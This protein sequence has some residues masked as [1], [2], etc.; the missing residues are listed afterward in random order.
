MSYA[1]D[2]VA[3]LALRTAA[4]DSARC[5]DVCDAPIEDEAEASRGLYV[6]ARGGEVHYEEPHLCE[7][8]ATA[9]GVTA[10]AAW[11]V[12]EEEG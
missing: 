9:I 7:S 5:C 10:L 11:S 6:W 1:V 2:A 12:E 4:E 3:D 8:C